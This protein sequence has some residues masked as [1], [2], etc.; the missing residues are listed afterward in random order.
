VASFITADVRLPDIIPSFEDE[1]Q[2][3]ASFRPLIYFAKP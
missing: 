3:L 1:T 2:S